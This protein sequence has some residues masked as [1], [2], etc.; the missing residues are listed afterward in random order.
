VI[1]VGNLQQY[2]TI[3]DVDIATFNTP[4]KHPTPT[5]PGPMLRE[6]LQ[7]APIL[8]KKRSREIEAHV[9]KDIF[10]EEFAASFVN[11]RETD[12]NNLSTMETDGG[13]RYHFFHKYTDGTRGDEPIYTACLNYRDLKYDGS[14]MFSFATQTSIKK[15]LILYPEAAL[16]S[17]ISEIDGMLDRKVWKGVLYDNLTN[18]QK[19]SICIRQP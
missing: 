13:I 4:A 9:G 8:G 7:S 6:L 12:T 11:K 10:A 2:E 17:L 5:S 19:Q 1:D 14:E 18:K 15:A 16:K 3:T